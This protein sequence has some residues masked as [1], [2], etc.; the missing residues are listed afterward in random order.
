MDV[1]SFV[2][3]RDIKEYLRQIEYRFSPLE[4]VWLIYTSEN[5][6]YQEKKQA[7]LE[8]IK[9]TED[10]EVPKRLNCKGW[11]SLH[12]FL[13]DYIALYDKL[14]KDFLSVSPEKG[15]VYTYSYHYL[16]DADW[17]E[18]EAV[19]NS[20]DRCMLAYEKERDYLDG[21]RMDGKTGVTAYSMKKRSLFQPESVMEIVYRNDGQVM[22]IVRHYPPDNEGEEDLL[23]FS[24]DG[25]WFDFPTPFEKGD[26]VWIPRQN[27]NWFCDDPFVL[28]GL[29]GWNPPASYLCG[30]GGDTTDM[31]AY[32]YFLNRDGTIYHEATYN[33]MDLEYYP[34][35]FKGNRQILPALS[36]FVKS[37]ISVDFLLCAYHKSML[38]INSEY[39][40]YTKER[41]RKNA[42]R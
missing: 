18:G 2:N 11:N 41:E 13:K 14:I 29:I 24:F 25:M 21:D 5:R 42:V 36:R 26:I 35:P 40:E 23:Y 31:T 1:Y 15:D 27:F 22:N 38:E 34:G 30:T 17:S 8:L 10:C 19:F 37:D 39:H 16:G 4:A 12:E 28:D 32:G 3:S 6:S 33:Y 9:T 20:F 7:W